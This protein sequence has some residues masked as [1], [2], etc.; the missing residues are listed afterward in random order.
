[1]YRKGRV[2]DR[3]VYNSIHGQKG[4]VIAYKK[5]IAEQVVIHNLLNLRFVVIIFVH[6]EKKKVAEANTWQPSE[7]RKYVSKK[8]AA[9]KLDNQLNSYHVK[10]S[11]NAAQNRPGD[12]PPPCLVGPEVDFLTRE[13]IDDRKK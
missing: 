11:S 6:K 1:M 13:E 7:P 9:R 5:K 4:K 12:I 2:F 3:N 10:K 8:Q